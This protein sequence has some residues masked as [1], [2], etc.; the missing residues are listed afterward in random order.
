MPTLWSRFHKHHS[1]LVDYW[2]VTFIV[3]MTKVL[4]DEKLDFTLWLV[5]W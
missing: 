1:C 5:C 2:I 4:P 3:E